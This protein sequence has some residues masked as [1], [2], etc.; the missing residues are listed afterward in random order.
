MRDQPITGEAR[1]RILA[2]A[3]KP[4]P[5]QLAI[6]HEGEEIRIKSYLLPL[7]GAGLPR[8]VYRPLGQLPQHYLSPGTR[9]RITFSLEGKIYYVATMVLGLAL[10]P[11]K[12]WKRPTPRSWSTRCEEAGSSSG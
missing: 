6:R 10:D 8:G 4:T 1:D 3:C 12:S 9:L 11:R 2:S 5:A 7:K